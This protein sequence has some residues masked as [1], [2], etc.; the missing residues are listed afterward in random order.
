MV[1]LLDQRKDDASEADTHRIAPTTSTRRPE[2][3]LPVGQRQD[4]AERDDDEGTLI[5]KIQRQET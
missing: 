5:A 4:Q 1:G 3:A 2:R